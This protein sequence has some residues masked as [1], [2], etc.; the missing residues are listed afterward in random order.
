MSHE[1][2]VKRLSDEIASLEQRYR[3][4]KNSVEAATRECQRE[5]DGLK[6]G[7]CR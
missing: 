6:E 1:E 7:W 4:Q 2:Q 5:M 3:A